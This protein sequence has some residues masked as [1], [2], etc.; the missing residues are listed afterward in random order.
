MPLL[1]STT[2]HFLKTQRITPR[3]GFRRGKR[4]RSAIVDIIPISPETQVRPGHFLCPDYFTESKIGSDFWQSDFL[5]VRE[6]PRDGPDSYQEALH[7]SWLIF[8]LKVPSQSHLFCDILITFSSVV[9]HWNYL[10]YSPYH[11]IRI[12]WLPVAP[13]HLAMNR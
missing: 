2:I 7:F 1:I 11:C 13:L 10:Y 4:E 12:I 3:N 5:E 6:K 8:F 9:L